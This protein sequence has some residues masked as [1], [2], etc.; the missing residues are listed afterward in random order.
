MG[1][2]SDF[3]D[4]DRYCDEHNIQPG[5]EPAAFAAWLNEKTEWDGPMGKVGDDDPRP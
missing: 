1:A 3:S 5:E 2:M 4:F